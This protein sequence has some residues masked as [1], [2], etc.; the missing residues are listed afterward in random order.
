MATHSSILAWKIPWT[1]ERGRL[2][3][4]GLQRVRHDLVT[5]PLNHNKCQAAR[6]PVRRDLRKNLASQGRKVR[7][8][9]LNGNAT[10]CPVLVWWVTPGGN[11]QKCPEALWLFFFS[12]GW[13]L[14]YHNQC[15]NGTFLCTASSCRFFGGGR[16]CKYMCAN[17]LL[18][19]LIEETV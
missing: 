8:A 9:G 6:C 1:E 17:P 3:S 10:S 15:Y 14:L 4:M 11:S 18:E 5:R 19:C 16:E 13:K 12:W 7:S 2:Q